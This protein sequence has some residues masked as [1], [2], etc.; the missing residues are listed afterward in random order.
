MI[1]GAYTPSFRIKEHPLEDADIYRYIYYIHT[2][3]HILIISWA[4][5]RQWTPWR[6]ILGSL[7]KI[8]F[9]S[10]SFIFPLRNRVWA[11]TQHISYSLTARPWKMI[12]RRSFPFGKVTF[13]G[14]TVKLPAGKTKMCLGVLGCPRKL[15]SKV[16]GYKPNILNPIYK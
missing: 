10:I 4:S 14:R 7:L 5:P 15:M 6:L 8:L 1:R 13:Q 12:R 9:A 11:T 16:L 2:Y 3:I